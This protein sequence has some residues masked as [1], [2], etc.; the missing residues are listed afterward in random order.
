MKRIDY[1]RNMPVEEIA[2]IIIA[3]N[4]A[5]D[6]CKSDCGDEDCMHDVECCVR[7]LEQEREEK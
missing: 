2:K 1:I 6:F 7:W 3:K 4:I 5:D